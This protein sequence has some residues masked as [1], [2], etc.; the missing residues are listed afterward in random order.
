MKVALMSLVASGFGPAK[1]G[2][3]EGWRR[4]RHDAALATLGRTRLYCPA[5]R[6]LASFASDAPE[7]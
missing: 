7:T 4:W 1:P 3:A 2:P 5:R 6:S